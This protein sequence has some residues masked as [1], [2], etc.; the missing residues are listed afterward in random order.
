MSGISAPSGLFKE[1]TGLKPQGTGLSQCLVAVRKNKPTCA[2]IQSGNI[3]ISFQGLR[4]YLFAISPH[5]C[6]IKAE[7]K[8]QCCCE[9]LLFLKNKLKGGRVLGS[10]LSGF[11]I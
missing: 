2:V 1:H 10:G 11:H 4:V 5:C 7:I 9:L 6:T 3:Y 8:H